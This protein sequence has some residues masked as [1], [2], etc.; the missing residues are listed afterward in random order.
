MATLTTVKGANLTNKEAEPSVKIDAS[1]EYGRLR[2]LYDSYT[3]DSGDEFGTDGLIRM[4]KIPK[5]ARLIDAE[6]SMP[7]SGA[8]GQFEVG[9]AA[10]EELDSS[11]SAVE[12][13]DPNGIFTTQDPG[14]AAVDRSRMLSTVPGYMKK[15]DA[16]V[17]VQVDFTEATADSGGDTLEL[18]CIIAVD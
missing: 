11:G 8:N 5:G 9:W 10:S 12:A 2:V 4:F 14:D 15:F 7:A 16:A 6:V 3:L 13:A 1:Q 18:V 17:E